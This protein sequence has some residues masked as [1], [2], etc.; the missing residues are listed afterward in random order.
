MILQA[1]YEYYQR[2]AADPGSTIAPHGLEWKEIPYLILIDKKGKFLE[3]QDTTEGVGKQKRAKKY[4]VVK[5]K[6]RPG[7]NS[8]QTANVFWDHFGYVLAQPKNT[9][10]KGMPKALDDA[11]KQNKTFIQEVRRLA[12]MYPSNEEIQAVAKFYDNPDNLQRIKMDPL[13]EECIK[14]DG[15]NISFKVAGNNTIVAANPDVTSSIEDCSD[16][17]EPTGICLITGKKAPIAILNSAIAIPGGKSGAK[18]V[19]FQKKSGY[20]SYYKEQGMNA[21]I[22]KEAE[23]AY[24]TALNSLLGKDSSN[25]YRLHDTSVV[26]WSQKPT[27]LEQ[28]FCF[29]FTSPPKDDPDKNTE[30]IR[31][32]LKSPFSGV[33]NDEDKTPFYVLGLSPNAARISVRFWR[34]GTVG[35]FASHIRQH[36]KDLEIIKSKNQRAY[37]SLFNLLTQVASLNKM[38][39]LPPSLASDLSQSIWDNQPYPTTLQMQCLIRI[40]ADR[41]ITSIRA[42]ILKAYLN[43]KFR[44]HNNPPKEIQMALDLENK[45]RRTYVAACLLSLKRSR[46]MLSQEQILRSK[47]VTMVQRRQPRQLYSAACCLYPDTTLQNLISGNLFIMK[48]YCKVL[49]P[50]WIVTGYLSIYRWMTSPVSQS[51]ITIKEKIYIKQQTKKK[52]NSI[53]IWKLQ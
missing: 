8:W 51:V 3:L 44:N 4:L 36:F 26:F 40:K 7:S 14:K 43:R 18:L 10:D 30:V 13:W 17:D 20:D 16:K 24:T 34:Q 53:Q 46:V 1:L 6:G 21:P 25:K 29:I 12:E 9:N 52:I 28:C 15:T 27:K 47:S 5:S 45:T 38:E 33:L 41:N 2:K 11:A 42:A 50:T 48:N 19:G 31:D 49:S 37:F 22:S 32:F 39:N 35:E 23:A